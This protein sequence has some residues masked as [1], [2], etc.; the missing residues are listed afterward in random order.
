M[1]TIILILT[2]LFC[3]SAIAN[4]TQPQFLYQPDGGQFAFEAYSSTS[5]ITSK[6]QGFQE[7]TRRSIVGGVALEYGF[8]DSF[9]IAIDQSYRSSTLEQGTISHDYS[10]M[11]DLL[12]EFKGNYKINGQLTLRYGA[13][14]SFGFTA[15]EDANTNPSN[16]YTGR[17]VVS[18]YLG[19][20]YKIGKNN[21]GALVSQEV[22]I[23]KE[24]TEDVNGNE[25]KATGAETTS[26]TAFYEYNFGNVLLGGGASYG[27]TSDYKPE[28]ATAREQIDTFGFTAYAAFYVTDSITLLPAVLYLTTPDDSSN[29]TPIDEYNVVGVAG[30]FRYTF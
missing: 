11:D 17:D 21:F 1:K 3:V 2:S 6:L 20:D 26:L 25:S 9:G 28:G 29:G 27:I 22:L 5:L 24:V 7:V 14:V 8:S 19:F 16:Q 15:E 13:D 23:G 4:T 18:P 12:I 30:N 10:G